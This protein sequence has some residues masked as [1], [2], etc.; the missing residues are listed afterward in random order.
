[1]ILGQILKLIL[2]NS[3]VGKFEFGKILFLRREKE[4]IVN[5]TARG[6]IDEKYYNF[7]VQ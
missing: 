2:E 4:T 1:M 7:P 5:V 6:E 3:E